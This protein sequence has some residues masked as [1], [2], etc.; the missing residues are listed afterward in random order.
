MTIRRTET[1]SAVMRQ[2]EKRPVVNGEL[3]LTAAAERIKTVP[4]D[5]VRI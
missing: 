4:A 1:R 2:V 5:A 3:S